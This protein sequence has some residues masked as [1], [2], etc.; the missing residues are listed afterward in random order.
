MSWAPSL[1]DAQASSRRLSEACF[2]LQMKKEKPRL[3]LWLLWAS[4]TTCKDKMSIAK[5]GFQIMFLKCIS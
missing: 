4:D 2:L 5:L 3:C 1:L